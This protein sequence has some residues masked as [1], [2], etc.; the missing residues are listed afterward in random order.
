VLATIVLERLLDVFAILLLSAAAAVSLRGLPEGMRQ[1]FWATAAVLGI[2]ALGILAL[3]AFPARFRALWEALTGP[4]PAR[5][6][7]LGNKLLDSA[8]SGLSA[9]RSPGAVVVL[10]GYSVAKWLLAAGM[11]WLSLWG[12]GQNVEPALA[13]LVVAAA[14]L[15]VTLPSVPGFFGVIQAAFVFA[16]TPFG[17]SREVALASSVFYL[18]AQWLPV[19]AIGLAFFFTTGL[20]P[21][22][23]RREVER[24]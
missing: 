12:Y 22:R 1:G 10:I 13:C 6:A 3:L 18:L 11:V 8:E 19:T 20:D 23:V 14:A 16:L 17:I 4:L 7:G 21:R 5:L 24:G 9:L 15:A 2:A